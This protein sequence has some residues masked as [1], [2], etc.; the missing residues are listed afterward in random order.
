MHIE[1]KRLIINNFMS[2]GHTDLRFN[3][4]GFIR[5]SGMNENPYDN[6]HSNGSGKSSLWEAIVWAITGET[7]R[8][9]K[10]IVNINGD[11][12][13]V[14]EVE[15]YIDNSRYQIIRS[16]DHDIRKTSLQILIN[17]E[18]VSGKG[19][20]DSE[21][22]LQQYLPDI[23]T[24]LLGSVVIL[25]QGLPQKFTNNT[26]SGR[27]EVLEKLSK[28]DFMI[29][30]L[31]TRVANRKKQLQT[32]LRSY[33]DAILSGTTR[34]TF[35][36]NQIQQQTDVLMSLN[37]E[38]LQERFNLLGG[39]KEQ[40][41]SVMDRLSQTAEIAN[42]D[43]EKL[44]AERNIV[45]YEESTQLAQISDDYQEK[46]KTYLD[47][48]SSL[49]AELTVSKNQLSAMKNIKDICPTCGQRLPDVH[50]P[51][52]SSLEQEILDK[53][54]KLKEILEILSDFQTNNA[55]QV[56]DVKRNF[57]TRK[58]DLD[59]RYSEVCDVYDSTRKE[60]NQTES[61][62]NII[63]SDLSKIEIQLAQLQTT[64]DTCNNIIRENNENLN[65]LTD[66][67]L[68]NNKQ[69]DLTQSHLDI[70]NKFETALKRDFRGYL[71]ST[72]ITFIEQRTKYY[73][74]MIFDTT[75]VTF[76]LDG[77]NIDIS[78]MNKPYENLSG[79]EK[80]KIDLIIQFSI[81]DMLSAQLGFTSNI[82]V[83]DEVFDGLDSIGCAKV[84]DMIASVSD[85]KN[86]FIVTHRKDL[87]IPTDK[88]LI[89]VKSSVGISEIKYDN[90]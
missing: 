76:A 41:L 57:L 37:K 65:V 63:S 67:I 2:F 27:K 87:S 6:A 43:K 17:G 20:R 36:E 42:Q 79:G 44:L 80:Q 77:N 83:L 47:A 64:I 13:C 14:V 40:L 50:K 22:L 69:R 8:G 73:S 61:R 9:T 89:V 11:N 86:I 28:S 59:N 35:L 15:F 19:I 48:K 38:E 10:N 71:L 84:I 49:T 70:V 46:T 12:G 16:K 62:L 55:K 34:K 18:D 30:D 88:E 75:N 23:T 52:T 56:S 25:G 53:D 26:P 3:D 51:D 66:E 31:K 82:L 29:E 54:T 4:D 81:R 33:E 68:Y 74:S 85:I 78:Y 32:D 7:I 39:E 90:I 45:V 24:S 72:V 58:A 1:F 5:V 60:K 21:K